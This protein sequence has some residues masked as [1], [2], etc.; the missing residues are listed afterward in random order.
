MPRLNDF[1]LEML[2]G[3][4]YAHFVT[5]RPDGSPQS[6]VVWVDADAERDQVLVN[7]AVGRLKERNLRRDPRV[8]VSVHDER[9]PGRFVSIGGAVEEFVA[10]EEAERHIDTLRRRYD[11]ESWEPVPGQQRV[12]LRIRPERILRYT[13]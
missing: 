10:G 3:L 6:T 4:N 12:L 1:D 7:T 2:R 8:S 9:D 5:L 13:G 11:G